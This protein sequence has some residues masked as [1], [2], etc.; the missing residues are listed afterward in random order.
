VRGSGGGAGCGGTSSDDL[1]GVACAFVS[2]GEEFT[3]VISK[4]KKVYSFGLN[5][6]AQLWH[7][8]VGL[9]CAEPRLVAGLVGEEF[10]AVSCHCNQG[11]VFAVLES[12][13]VYTWGITSSSDV[14][15]V[16]LLSGSSDNDG[17]IMRC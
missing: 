7:G 13:D 14:G 6:C 15:R 12:G 9:N 11:Q 17:A 3:V 5:V 1:R 8:T 4:Q 16:G 2:C 10:R